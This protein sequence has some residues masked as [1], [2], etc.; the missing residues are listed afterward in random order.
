MLVN[1]VSSRGSGS[2]G[3]G[4]AL[5]ESLMRM[6]PDASLDLHAPTDWRRLI[7]VPAIFYRPGLLTKAIVDQ[8][9]IPSRTRSG[10][11][12]TVLTLGDTGSFRLRVR[13]VLFVQ[14]AWLTVELQDLPF[15]IPTR[16][17]GRVRAMQTYF[18]FGIDGVSDY[19][20]Q[21]EWMRR[22]LLHRWSLPPSRVHVVRHGPVVPPVAIDRLPRSRGAA[23]KEIV[24]FV[25]SN[26]GP[27]KNLDILPAIANRLK[28]AE[29]SVKFVVT[30][31]PPPDLSRQP[32]AIS[33]I[34]LI[35]RREVSE[36]MIAS[37]VVVIPSRLE[38][39]G[40]SYL[41]AMMLG[42]PLVCADVP[43]AREMCG[44]RAEF[45]GPDDPHVWADRIVEAARDTMPAAERAERNR[46]QLLVSGFD[47]DMAG[48][49]M[50]KLLDPRE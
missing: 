9:L 8:I 30:A 49:R 4:I 34:G 50:W 5:V 28:G 16:F 48:M 45:A 29:Q 32:E 35:S 12:S 38:S 47:W 31:S 44:G 42:S 6:R 43:I 10:E 33:Y 18:R 26:I 36:W 11:I 1:A 25:P 17:R 14:Q 37:D 7:D 15:P 39:F 13:H 24:A 22:S 20:V 21:S 27:H 23:S 46:V 40:L 41:E 19:V 2:L 3:V